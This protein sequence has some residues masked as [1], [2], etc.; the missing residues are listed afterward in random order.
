M[1]YL[2][3]QSGTHG[4]VTRAEKLVGFVVILTQGFAVKSRSK[5]F[6]VELKGAVRT[7]NF[8][9]GENGVQLRAL[10]P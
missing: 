8:V 6:R 1:S 10:L 7:T 2:V 3:G 9:P 5:Q 4:W